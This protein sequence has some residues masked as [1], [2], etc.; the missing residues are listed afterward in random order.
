M[1]TSLTVA[2]VQMNSGNCV[3]TNLQ[4]ARAL[5]EQACAT[6]QA[7]ELIL[8]PENCAFMGEHA[9]DVLSIAETWGNGPIQQ[10]F[11][12]LATDL[13]CHIIAGSI[14]I[15]DTSANTK[16]FTSSVV[17]SP[18][19][20]D[21]IRYDKIHLF[22]V[23]LPNGER[24]CES[25]RF[26]AGDEPVNLSL[27]G[28]EIG[29]SICYDLRF[30]ELYRQLAADL[31]TVPAAFTAATGEAHW[32]ALLRA[33]AIENQSYVI[34]ANQCGQHPNQ[35]QTWGHSMIISPWGEILAHLDTDVGVI[36]AALSKD[37]LSRL[38][39]SFPCQQHRKL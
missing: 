17:F 31:V 19:Q 29:L 33:R 23:V 16:V 1:S 26:I 5:C 9:T 18:N 13:N 24:Y 39:A 27:A 20:A 10:F 7:T 25:D 28:F 37:E 34:A 12:T 3:D 11:H 30:P 4:H 6:Q 32:E 36:H 35:R 8:L 15:L 14:P 2:A 22:D 38:R 21:R